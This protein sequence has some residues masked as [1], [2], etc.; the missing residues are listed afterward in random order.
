MIMVNTAIRPITIPYSDNIIIASKDEDTHVKDINR[1]LA[2]LKNHGW[3]F[4]LAKCHWA[5]RKNLK[6]FGMLVNLEDGTISP[7]WTRG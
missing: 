1:V 7:T 3:K 4:K 2:A 5:V 6:I